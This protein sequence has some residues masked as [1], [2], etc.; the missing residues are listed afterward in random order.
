MKQINPDNG[1]STQELGVRSDE[2]KRLQVTG[3]SEEKL[4]PI[5]YPL[6]PIPHAPCPIYPK[7]VSK[8]FQLN[9]LLLITA[10]A[11]C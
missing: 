3:D 9:Q 6:Y 1:V 4:Y 8:C 7:K 2:G 11:H 10:L 5:P